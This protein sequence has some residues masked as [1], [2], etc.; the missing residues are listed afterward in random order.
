MT[1]N[2]FLEYMTENLSAYSSFYKKALAFQN[3]KNL[4]RKKKAWN[5]AKVERA[6]LAMWKQ[7]MQGLY[8]TIKPQIGNRASRE[9]WIEFMIQYELLE[10]ISNSMSEMEFE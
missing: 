7:S 2:E 1:F 4:A 9:E 6:T 3:K 10:N 5:E 8:D